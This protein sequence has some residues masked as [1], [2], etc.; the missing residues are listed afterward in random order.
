[1]TKDK[2]AKLSSTFSFTFFSSFLCS[3]EFSLSK[4]D[5][6]F[7]FWLCQAAHESYFPDQWS[8]PGPCGE[9]AE[10]QPLTGPLGKYPRVISN[11]WENSL[12]GCCYLIWPC[13]NFFAILIQ[14]LG[15]RC[16]CVEFF[17]K[18]FYFWPS[19]FLVSFH[20]EFY[21]PFFS[22]RLCIVGVAVSC[23]NYIS[24]FLT[25]SVSN[26]SHISLSL[27]YISLG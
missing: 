4:S 14:F 1:M 11:A 6:F 20:H 9:S 5:F 25:C 23:Y 19:K 21:K 10:S 16:K 2:K 27:S 13:T 17:K 8:N 7:F 3:C 18:H 12:Q 22:I 24:Q 26:F 15:S